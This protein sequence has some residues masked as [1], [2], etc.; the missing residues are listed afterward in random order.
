M[1]LRDFQIEKGIDVKT[2]GFNEVPICY[3]S[4]SIERNEAV[5]LEDLKASGFEMFDRFKEVTKEY[6]MKTMEALGKYH[7]LSFALRDQ[8]P[9]LFEPYKSMEDIFSKRNQESM[10]HIKSWFENL[11]KQAYDALDLSDNEGMKSRVREH[12]KKDFFEMIGESVDGA[13]AEPYTVVCH[14]DCW[15]NNIMYRHEVS[16]RLK[17]VSKAE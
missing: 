12:L 9:E 5:F 4:L 8:K 11:K 14:G 2:D 16:L 6:A 15:N 10:A 3:K 1:K 17:T 7:A 13:A